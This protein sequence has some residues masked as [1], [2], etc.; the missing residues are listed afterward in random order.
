MKLVSVRSTARLHPLPCT[1]AGKPVPLQ[2]G[3]QCT[4]PSLT[5]YSTHPGNWGRKQYSWSQSKDRLLLGTWGG[6]RLA[7]GTGV[8]LR[9]LPKEVIWAKVSSITS[10]YRHL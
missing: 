5:Y 3:R 10:W 7:Q 9:V 2:E 1:S 6:Q 8:G 4:D